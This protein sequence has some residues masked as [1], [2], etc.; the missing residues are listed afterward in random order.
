MMMVMALTQHLP[1]LDPW[2]KVL[3]FSVMQAGQR[4][5]WPRAPGSDILKAMDK[6]IEDGVNVLSMSLGGGMSDY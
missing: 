6:A 3:A 1:R 2:W 4:V 5:G